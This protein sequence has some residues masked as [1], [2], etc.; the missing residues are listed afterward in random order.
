LHYSK[1]CLSRDG[2]DTC[3]HDVTA[4]RPV[5][6]GTVRRPKSVAASVELSFS[7]HQYLRSVFGQ[8]EFS[9]R[10]MQVSVAP[11]QRCAMWREPRTNFACRTSAEH[12]CQAIIEPMYAGDT[13]NQDYGL[14]SIEEHLSLLSGVP[15]A[16]TR[17]WFWDHAMWKFAAA[18]A[19]SM[20]GVAVALY[21]APG[22]CVSR[23]E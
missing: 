5:K 21:A 10:I 18:G 2:G 14:E 15:L 16:G 22:S 4:A 6:T 13:K 20:R 11:L 3:G 1:F 17:C 12:V 9:V 23:S 7:I 19:Q 8:S